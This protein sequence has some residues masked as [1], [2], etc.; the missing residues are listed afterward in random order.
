VSMSLY[1]SIMASPV[2]PMPMGHEAIGVVEEVGPA[3][4]GLRAGD[5]VA[6][7]PVT[8]CEFYGFK[9]CPSCREG[10]YQH[11]FCLLGVGDG[12]ELEE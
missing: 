4:R 7:N 6:Y 1:A 10:N 9:P 5:R 12:S 11:C 3:V 2:N 8:R